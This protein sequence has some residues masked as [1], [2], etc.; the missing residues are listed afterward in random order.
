MY[1]GIDMTKEGLSGQ[2]ES[3]SILDE[4]RAQRAA[5]LAEIA[6]GVTLG[7]STNPGVQ[8]AYAAL[9]AARQLEEARRAERREGSRGAVYLRRVG[10]RRGY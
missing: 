8:T 4:I 1:N 6:N 10:R 5:V 2:S 7:M 3:P 9:T